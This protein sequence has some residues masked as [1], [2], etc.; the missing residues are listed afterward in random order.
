MSNNYKLTDSIN[1]I[2]GIG[3]KKAQAFQRLGVISLYDLIS[4]FPRAYEDRSVICNLKDTFDG[5]FCC[6]RGTVATEP[7]LTRIR[8]GLDLVKFKIYDNSGM[9]DVTFFNQSYIKN[10]FTK[11]N[12]YIFYGKITAN[13]THRSMTNPVFDNADNPKVTG[14]IIPIYRLTSGLNQKTIYQSM[15]IALD[16]CGDFIP[17]LIPEYLLRKQ[18]LCH[19]RYA[20]QNIHFPTDYA[21]RLIA[22]KRLVYEELFLLALSLGRLKDTRKKEAGL[23]FD[24]SKLNIFLDALPFK[25]TNAQLNA[26][27]ECCVDISSGNAMSRLIQ[28]D[29]G[30]GKTVVAAALV[31]ICKTSSFMSALLAPTEILAEQHYKTLSALLGPLGVKVGLLTGSSTNR[32]KV[33]KELADG[34]I[35]FIIGTHALFSK[36]VEYKN[37]GLIITDEQHRFGVDQRAAMISKGNSPHVLVMSA[38]PIPRTLA[39]M[40]YG[41]LDVSIIDELPPGRQTV[42]TY[43]VGE[44]YRGR[45]NSFINKQCHSHNQVYVVCPMIDENEESDLHLKSAQEHTQYLRSQLPHLSIECVHGK[46]KSQEKDQIMNRFSNGQID[47]LVST[48]VIEVGVD[49]PNATLIIIENADRFGLSQLHQ[50][51]GRVGRGKNKSYCVLVSDLDTD[52]AK[53]RLEIMCKTNN[54][55]EISEEDLRL[56]GPGDFFGNRQHGLPEMHLADLGA[57]TNTLK[58][59]KDDADELLLKDPQL[60]SYPELKQKIFELFNDCQGR[61]N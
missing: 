48:T 51:R 44:N 7:H 19:A 2:K 25:L 3:E 18:Q 32:V 53:A 29:V 6:I 46:I 16:A 56:R 31:Y 40:I 50:L 1:N 11:G 35:D 33:K 12:E 4:F 5:Q 37:L 15:E 59:A 42:D 43:R 55:F 45:L 36:D 39:L 57:D 52:E 60:S 49:V 61:L 10:S 34:S 24:I 41:D 47:V 26:I 30:S 54:G 8:H 58:M 22:K 38:T 14:R 21:S 13:G 27:K 9:A 23:V 17:E 20:Y 28:G